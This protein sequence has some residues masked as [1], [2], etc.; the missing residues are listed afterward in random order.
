M[1]GIELQETTPIVDDTAGPQ[2]EKCTHYQAEHNGPNDHCM[3][4][5]ATGKI[6]EAEEYE[7]AGYTVAGITQ[8]CPCRKFL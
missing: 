7:K 4:I 3:R 5:I 1:S 2:C 8:R 6:P